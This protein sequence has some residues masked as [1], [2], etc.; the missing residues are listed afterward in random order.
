VASLL[1]EEEWRISRQAALAALAA[2]V[3]GGAV[4]AAAAADD[5]LYRAIVR[6]DALLEWL[7]VAAWGAALALALVLARRTRGREC[8]FWV[9]FGVGAVAA[10]GEE[11]SWGQRILGFGTPE[12]LLD[13]DKQEEATLHN[14]E[15][16]EA[17]TRVAVATVAAAAA[18]AAWTTA[19]V[20]RCLTTAFVLVAGYE[21]LRLA[22]GDS[23]PY[24]VAKWSEWPETCLAGG[25]AAVA[26][27]TLR[28]LESPP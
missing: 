16:L 4:V 25:L 1:R 7:Q 8:A 15:E 10:L 26:A 21:L 11:L 9:L 18:V 27:L 24:W 23:P 12:P 22:G 13:R 2:P 3:V 20:P 28:R 5:T 19:R 14:V 17:P 6:E